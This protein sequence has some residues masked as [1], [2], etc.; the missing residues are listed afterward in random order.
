I[1][2]QNPSIVL[3]FL[4]ITIKSFTRK[5][6]IV[7]AHNSGIFPFD[8]NS[9]ILNFL[10]KLICSKESLVIV[11][12]HEIAS[13]VTTYRGSPFALPD[14]IPSMTVEYATTLNLPDC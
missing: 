14:P 4:A 8:G 1:F 6:V 7:D 10:T 3:G 5:T 11:T 13:I 9:F 12:N 2:A